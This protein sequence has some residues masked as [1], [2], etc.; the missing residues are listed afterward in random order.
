MLDR[1]CG[2]AGWYRTVALQRPQSLVSSHRNRTSHRCVTTAPTG[3]FLQRA[4]A[5]HTGLIRIQLADFDA[6]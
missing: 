4:T 3:N 1:Q 6:R 2:F 5:S